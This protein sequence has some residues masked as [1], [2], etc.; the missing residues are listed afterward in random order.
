MLQHPGGDAV[1]LES[2]GRD[3]TFAF[4]SA[5]HNE[6][7]LTVLEPYLIGVLPPEQRMFK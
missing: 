6:T 1:L 2:G 4:Q 3:A 7:M 5:G